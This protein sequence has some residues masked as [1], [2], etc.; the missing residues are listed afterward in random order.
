MSVL[1]TGANG[2]LA[3]HIILELL[4]RGYSIN[5]LLR[6]KDK[7]QLKEAGVRLYEGDIT[8]IED[9]KKAASHC[10]IIIH[11]AA[12]TSQQASRYEPFEKVNVKGTEN[13][14]KA[15]QEV[16]VRKIVY[17]STAN[18]FGYGS[19]S[20]PG[21]ETLPISNLFAQSYYAFS[22]WEAQNSLIEY[23]K[24]NQL[25]EIIIVNPTFILGEYANQEGSGKAVLMAYKK[26]VQFVPPGGKNFVHAKDVAAGVCQ[27][28]E[29][30]K[31]GQAYL[32]CQSNLSYKDFFKMVNEVTSTKSF[33]VTLPGFLLQ[34]IGAFG[35][36]LNRIGMSTPVNLTNMKILCIKNYYTNEKASKELELTFS[37]SVSSAISD[38]VVW[39][40]KTGTLK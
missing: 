5:G 28:L 12:H 16:G 25:P 36:L 10:A 8:S 31:H 22:K 9:I 29:K 38:T 32:L 3:T 30:G 40:K 4:N 2:F 21:N 11:V 19:A 23:A 33:I 18:T 6:N 37:A 35:S 15:A 24:V 13:V 26:W 14:L 1:V 27:A 39:F 7:F 34:M 17:V 20:Q